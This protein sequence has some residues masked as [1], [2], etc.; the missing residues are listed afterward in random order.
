[1]TTRGA[2][3]PSQGRARTDP[4]LWTVLLVVLIVVSLFLC[5]FIAFFLNPS[6]DK[7][8]Y[9][10]VA[11]ITGESFTNPY[12]SA[13]TRNS[14]GWAL[15]LS[16]VGGPRLDLKDLVVAIK[17]PTSGSTP[18]QVW[19]LNVKGGGN[20]S[21]DL[22]YEGLSTRWYLKTC[23]STASLR[24]A[25][26]TVPVTLNSTTAPALREDQFSTVEGA[27]VIFRDIDLDGNLSVQDKL[28]VYKDAN[29][30]GTVDLVSGTLLELQ[31]L[32]GKLVSSAVLK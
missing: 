10:P 9:N 23:N 5:A 4:R 24:Y 22:S 14:G 1:M 13:V 8:K 21:A 28:M 26:G 7:A 31:T 17:T 20:H 2:A 3:Q 30:D 6:L 11:K 29:G 18:S 12:G 25:N 27:V 15:G 19:K 16:S 32:D